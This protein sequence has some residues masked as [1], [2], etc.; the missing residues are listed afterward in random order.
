MA[1]SDNVLR[2]GLTSKHVDVPEL[3]HVL[4]FEPRK[5]DIIDP[6]EVASGRERYPV[7]IDEFAL[8][9]LASDTN[10]RAV[11]ERR[12]SLEIAICT[13]GSF[14]LEID[15]AEGS[16]SPH[17]RKRYIGQGESFVVPYGVE[18]YS[19]SGSGEIYFATVPEAGD[20]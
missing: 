13:K 9:R 17:R 16:S 10:Y 11:L 18:A 7:P 14:A 1:N 15:E 12:S 19:L 2:G 8:L 3:M 4:D 6:E 5:P 20:S